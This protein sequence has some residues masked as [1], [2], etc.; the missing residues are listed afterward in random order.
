MT[1]R[2]IILGKGVPP[3]TATQK[4]AA[5][6]TAAAAAVEN[7]GTEIHIYELHTSLR[8]DLSTPNPPR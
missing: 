3:Q 1:S 4:A 5:L 6:A 2:Y 8:Q 7:P